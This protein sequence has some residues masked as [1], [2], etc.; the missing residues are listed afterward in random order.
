MKVGVLF[1]LAALTAVSAEARHEIMEGN[2]ASPVRVVIYEDLQCS[3]CAQLRQLLDTRVLPKYGT[4]AVFIH[5]DFPLARHSW[6]RP[7]AIAARWVYERNPELG[8]TFRREILAE[9]NNISP[10]TLKAWLLEFASRNNLDQKGIL[11]SLTDP[12]L[13]ALVEQDYQGGVARGVSKTPTAFISNIP[14]VETIIYDDI[15]RA[16]DQALAK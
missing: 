2:P 12:R 7:A 14:L 6:A 11:D 13:A 8:L 9:Q 4:K 10:D 15:A 5:R 16:L 3:D 1:L